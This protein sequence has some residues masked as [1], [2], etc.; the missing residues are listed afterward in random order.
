MLK[1]KYNNGEPRIPNLI[2]FSAF[3]VFSLV[4]AIG[5]AA[6]AASRDGKGLCED[7]ASRG[8]E[9][10][11]EA[12]I[13]ITLTWI[14]VMIGTSSARLTPDLVSLTIPTSYGGSCPFVVGQKF[15]DVQI[16]WSAR[17]AET[18]EGT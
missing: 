15:Q 13:A 17:L 14:S 10:C 6:R 9:S 7:L 18:R 5:L 16:E 12:A 1:F 3:F 4:G 11:T 2:A 8:S